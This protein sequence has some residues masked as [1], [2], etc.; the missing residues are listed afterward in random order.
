[1]SFRKEL[2][3]NHIFILSLLILAINDH[4]LKDLYHNW[5]TGKISDF[6]GLIVLPIF[7]AFLFPKITKWSCHISALCFVFWKT[8]FSSG[9]IEL[10][11]RNDIFTI[12]RII[13]YSDFIALLILP[14]PW[15]IINQKD[16]IHNTQPTGN[17]RLTVIA[18]TTFGVL[19][20]TSIRLTPTLEPQGTIFIG[21]EY[22]LKVSKDTVL[23]RIQQLGYSY[24]VENNL[25]R[26]SNIVVPPVNDGRRFRV[27]QDTIK[28]LTF[29]FMDFPYQPTRKQEQLGAQ[30]LYIHDVKFSNTNTITDWRLMKKYSKLYNKISGEL[31]AKQTTKK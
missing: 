13:D 7:I 2:L 27:D 20:A 3:L 31:F 23:A 6:A 29:S 9:L 21:Q 22:Y 25:Y 15:V 5:L 24:E 8:E 10:L 11:N 30:C 19:T 16:R 26:I 14:I 1:M 28:E 17:F 12:S 18:L 4:V